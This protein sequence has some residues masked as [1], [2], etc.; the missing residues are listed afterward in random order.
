MCGRGFCENFFKG[1]F[2]GYFDGIFLGQVN[3]CELGSP[4]GVSLGN[5]EWT[6]AG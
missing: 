5:L 2:L 4:Y 1:V 6:P 3:V